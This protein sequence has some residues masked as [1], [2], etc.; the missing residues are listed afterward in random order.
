M[1]ETELYYSMYELLS[2]KKNPERGRLYLEL[3]DK[4]VLRLNMTAEE[5]N[6]A[7]VL[8]DDSKAPE[9]D[10]Y[11]MQFIDNKRKR[12]DLVI[13]TNKRFIPVEVKIEAS[14]QDTQCY[15]YWREAEKYH[16]N[17][18]FSEPPVLYY[19]SPEGYFPSIESAKDFGYIGDLN[20]IRLDKIDNVAFRSEFLHWLEACREQTPK[21]FS[22]TRRV[23]QLYDEIKEII[24]RLCRTEP[25]LENLMYKFFTALDTRFDENFCK[26]Y[27]LKRGSNRRGEIG[28][29]HTYRRYIDRFFGKEFAEA[30]I[31]L[32]C[33][34]SVGNVIKFGDDKELWFFVESYN[35]GENDFKRARTLIA[36]FAIYDSSIYNALCKR[37]DIKRLLGGK[38]ILPQDFIKDYWQKGQKLAGC[39]GLTVLNDA[40]GNM[41]DFYDVDKTLAQFRTQED[42]D[43][44]VDSVMIEIEKLLERFING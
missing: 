23:E 16:K 35:G 40:H 30:A 31:V 25:Y 4:H 12:I 20:L 21:S 34:D 28:D 42:I 32:L 38:N 15:D 14:D 37:D 41:I 27:R 2:P 11:H 8:V 1:Q 5:L 24:F 10:R 26:R 19:L 22:C 36:A 17:H 18:S 29:Y 33:T 3:F 13:I 7:R 39:I 9:E 44:A 43:R 6:S